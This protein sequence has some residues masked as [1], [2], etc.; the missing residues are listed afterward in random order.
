MVP[1][2]TL[3]HQIYE[4]AARLIPL[5]SSIP[6]T[7]GC[8]LRPSLPSSP[9]LEQRRDALFAKPPHILITTPTALAALPELDIHALTQYVRVIAIDEADSLIFV[10]NGKETVATRE[11]KKEK[12][13]RTVLLM[14]SIFARKASMKPSGTV[15]FVRKP[16]VVLISATLN[17]RFR[18]HVEQREKW[19]HP[20]VG[21]VHIPHDSHVG[22]MMPKVLL[23]LSDG[24]GGEGRFKGKVQHHVVVVSP[25]G[26]MRNLESEPILP[27]EP[28]LIP[29]VT[30]DGKPDTNVQ[31]HLA[32]AIAELWAL[33]EEQ[34]Q[35]DE[36]EEGGGGWTGNAKRRATLVVIPEGSRATQLSK[37]LRVFGLDARGI[38]M[39]SEEDRAEVMT[40]TGGP[41]SNIKPSPP[42][43][44]SPTN[45]ADFS[46]PIYIY[47]PSQLRGIDIPSLTQ[48]LLL[49]PAIDTPSSYVHLS[50]RVGRM[51][52]S[53]KVVVLVEGDAQDT[54]QQ[55]E[56]RRLAAES[57]NALR[58]QV[59]GWAKLRRIERGEEEPVQG[60]NF[61]SDGR[62]GRV[63]RVMGP[64]G[65]TERLARMVNE[66][67]EGVEV[68]RLEWVR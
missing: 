50:G 58:E 39:D 11:R 61:E 24:R 19:I 10:P 15:G 65:E 34:A 46:S 35:K 52:R 31:P 2:A 1:S 7:I 44:S 56:Q 68:E 67:V 53:G 18:H 43:F 59:E 32:E 37:D 23:G 41:A 47:S 6:S 5:K 66:K 54:E 14:R 64:V 36:E 25:S 12:P 63:R 16:Q 9:S 27:L 22:G 3:A 26:G 28:P 13:S 20:G 49:S 21:T 62:E 42:P 40:R 38:D 45:S 8:L 29:T 55:K 60:D 30:D 4:W 57:A 17:R 33:S 51:G 48:V